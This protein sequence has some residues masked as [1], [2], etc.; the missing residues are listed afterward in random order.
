M[1]AMWFMLF[2]F[3]FGHPSLA[4]MQTWVEVT[5]PNNLVKGFIMVKLLI[6]YFYSVIGIH[7]IGNVKFYL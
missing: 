6:L 7:V 3:W 1:E 5:E 2:F 4:F